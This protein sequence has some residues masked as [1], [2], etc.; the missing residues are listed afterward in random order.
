MWGTLGQ[1]AT[2]TSAR[3]NLELEIG[4]FTLRQATYDAGAHVAEHRH[5]RPSVV[6]GV[7]GPCIES[8]G[9]PR[10]VRRRLTFLPTGYTHSLDYV[11]PTQVFAIEAE[12]GSAEA[13]QLAE[14]G[15]AVPLPASLYDNIWD[16]LLRVQDPANL[17]AVANAVTTFWTRSASYLLGRQPRWL[18]ALLEQ[19]HANWESPPS[20]TALARELGFSPQFLCRAFKRATGLTMRQYNQAI[21]LDYARGLLWGSGQSVSEIAGVTGFS[22]QSHLTRVLR[23]RMGETPTSLRSRSFVPEVPLRHSY[24]RA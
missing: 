3:Q 16:I 2:S 12:P 14:I 23:D 19:L 18:P 13:L 11:A 10:I 1:S 20:A 9:G 4:P 17:P 6:Y 22:D 7:G 5:D 15:S 21:R 24:A 8:S